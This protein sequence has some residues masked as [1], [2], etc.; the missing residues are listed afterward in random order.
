VGKALELSILAEADE[1]FFLE[2]FKGQRELSSPTRGGG[3][4]AKP[5]RSNERIAV[6][7]A[8]DRNGETFDAVLDVIAAKH[9][10]AA[11]KPVLGKD[12]LLST[13]G[14]K[15]S[16]AMAKDAG[17]P[18]QAMNIRAGIRVKERIFHIQNVKPTTAG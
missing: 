12:T 3:K 16:K 13:D 6:L 15:A 5:G 10:G 4:A 8:R 11:R 9:L 14:S 17:I 2:S 18:H 7:I 1:T